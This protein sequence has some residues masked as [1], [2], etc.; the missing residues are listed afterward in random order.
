MNKALFLDRDGVINVEKNYV[1]KIEDFEFMDGIFE[2]TRYFQ[3]QGYLL[4]VITNQ[5]GIGKGYYTEEQFHKLNDWMLNEFK[6]RGIHFTEVYY[7]PYH[8]EGLGEYKKQSYDRKP[9]PGMIMKAI[10]KYKIDPGRSI[11]IG[12]NISDIIAGENAKI[13]IRIW[14]SDHVDTT[15]T[16]IQKLSIQNIVRAI[17]LA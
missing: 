17:R 8:P 14:L 15:I 4:F 7:C 13:A 5:A 12:D 2:V 3:N 1:H 9:N 10:D 11:L 16:T 6:Q